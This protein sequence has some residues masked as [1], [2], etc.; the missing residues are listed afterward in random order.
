MLQKKISLFIMVTILFHFSLAWPVDVAAETGNE[1]VEEWIKQSEQ[2]EDPAPEEGVDADPDRPVGVT[3]VDV[4]RSIFALLFVISLLY[5]LLKWLQ[6]KT[7]PISETTL[8]KNL[9]GTGVG[10]DRSV[11]LIKIG[12]RILVVGVG[13]NVT[14]LKEISDSEEVAYF[15]EA[16]ET[17]T[18]T[19][20]E[21][22]DW[23]QR[24]SAFLPDRRNSKKVG[25]S[26]QKEFQ[27]QLAA[28]AR[29]RKRVLEDGK[30]KEWN[31][32]E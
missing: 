13:E 18:G 29:K 10:N 4:I 19:G 30:E 28:I 23:I 17:E 27:E 21:K 1:S 22:K 5:L 14:L 3:A 15:L 8:V 7:A 20:P 16:M 26:F 6:K 11:Q 31:R 12:N 2:G 25:Q 32:Y 9:G 24:L